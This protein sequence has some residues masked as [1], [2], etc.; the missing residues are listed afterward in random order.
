VRDHIPHSTF[1]VPRSL[2]S[3][4]GFTIFELIIFAAVLSLIVVAFLT[5]L[6][7]VTRVHVRQSAAAE[8]NQQSQF[9]L[10][11]I[12]YHVEQS[13]IIELDENAATSTL[14]LRMS[15]SSSD[16]TYIYLSANVMYLKQTDG[17]AAQPLTSNKVTVSNLSFTKRAHARAADS[18]S[19][20]FTIAYNTQNVGEQF[21]QTLNTAVARV[22]A[23][24]F[25]SNLI[26]SSTATYDVG[27]TSQVWRSI[28]NALY[29]SGSN[30][31]VGISS[32]GQTLEV[33][34]GV[35]LNTTAAKPTCD[36]SQRGTFW[37]TQSAGGV[38]DAVQVC[39]KSAADAYAW[40]TI[41]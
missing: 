20:N 7:S 1:H 35:R 32:P 16:P 10:Q 8:V 26:P 39:A 2:R 36:A 11:T 33:N 34:G 18:V 13:S 21:S 30:V 31:G 5:I 29:F 3:R 14:K 19:V 37:V 6:V 12:Q 17:G 24:T 38:Q 4:R 25:D 15:A 9:L 40:R 22:N 28:N 27:V 23:A 41:Y